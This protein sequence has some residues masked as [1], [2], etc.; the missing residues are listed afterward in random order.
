P[1]VL[2]TDCSTNS[3]NWTAISSSP[4]RSSDRRSAGELIFSKETIAIQGQRIRS[5][6]ILTVTAHNVVGD[7]RQM[8][9]GGPQ[10]QQSGVSLPVQGMQEV[11]RTVK[12]QDG[13]I[14]GLVACR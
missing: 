7:A 6:C 12:P 11:T 1:P 5:N 3:R 4:D 13:D 9:A 14:G 10:R 2:D 8:S